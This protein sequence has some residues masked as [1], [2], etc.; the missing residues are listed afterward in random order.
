MIRIYSLKDLLILDYTVDHGPDW[1]KDKL[2]EDGSF[3]LRKTFTFEPKDLLDKSEREKIE[4]AV[5]ADEDLEES[6]HDDPFDPEIISFILGRLVA[7]YYRID[8]AKITRNHDVYLHTSMKLDIKLFVSHRHISVFAKLAQFLQRDI[9]VGG[10]AENTIPEQ[11][12]WDLIK[13]FPNTHQKDLYEGS[14]ITSLIRDYVDNIPDYRAKYEK[15]INKR[16]TVKASDLGH[17]LK[18]QELHKF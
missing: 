10:E 17:I 4:R 7:D 3:T 5:E 18:D 1:V 2:K 11:I 14:V 12:M 6:E 13:R 9:F 8:K 16:K 15:Y